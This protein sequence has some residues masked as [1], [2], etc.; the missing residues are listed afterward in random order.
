[1]DYLESQSKQNIQKYIDKVLP[2]EY[3]KTPK[4]LSL[5]LSETWVAADKSQ[6]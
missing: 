5:I 6:N 1:L 4:G 2:L 3:E